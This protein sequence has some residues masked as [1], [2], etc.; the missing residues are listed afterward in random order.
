MF[1]IGTV[2]PEC[3][4]TI[5]FLLDFLIY[6]FSHLVIHWLFLSN[7]TV[8][9]IEF[10]STFRNL[11]LKEGRG[12]NS[13]NIYES[14]IHSE[15]I[16]HDQVHSVWIVISFPHLQVAL[17]RQQAQE[18]ELGICSPVTLSGPEVMVKNEAEADCLF[19]VE[20]QSP[21]PTSSSAPS[22]GVTGQRLPVITHLLSHHA[23]LCL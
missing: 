3:Y 22:L 9:K 11:W 7:K 10:Y 6:L 20:G 15:A 5:L 19:S 17:R 4:A 16:F 14:W 2:E 8:N 23:T 21:T 18:E 12:P 13:V 1:C